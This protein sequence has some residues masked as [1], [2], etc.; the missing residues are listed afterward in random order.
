MPSA[1]SPGSRFRGRFSGKTRVAARSG[2]FYVPLDQPLANVIAAALEP[3]TQS[4][5]AANRV[6]GLP[7]I[8]A[9]QPASVRSGRT[10]DELP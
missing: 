5:Y 9:E 6:L 10:Y 1:S 2:D 8:T 7:R 4:S 3:E